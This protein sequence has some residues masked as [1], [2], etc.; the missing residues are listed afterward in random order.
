MWR[1]KSAVLVGLGA[2]LGA[3][4]LV[5][6]PVLAGRIL[7]PVTS[8]EPVAGT[9][10][11]AVSGDGR[12]IF[13]VS[14]SNN[15]GPMANGALNLYRADTSAA[16]PPE[17]SLVLALSGLGNGNCF[18][19]SASN[20]GTV[21]AFETLAT[22]LGG[23]QG[24]FS[25]I[26][27][28][29]QIA[30]PQNEVGFDTLLVSRGLGGVAPNG[31]SRYA[32]TSGD[33]RFVAFWSDASNLIANDSNS[34]PDI[35]IVNVDG[36]QLG[37]T[38]RISVDSNEVQIAGWSRALSN[39]AV[40]GDGRYVV[41]AADATLDGAN[42][43]T[44]EDVYLRDRTAGTTTLLSRFSNGTPFNAAADQ[45]SISPNARYVAFRSFQTGAGIGPSRIFLRDRQS[46]TTT[47]IPAPPTTAACAEPRVSDDADIAMNCAS[48][49]VGVSQQVWFRRGSDGAF[50]RLSSTPG[51]ADGNGASGT[52]I[53][54][55][56]SGDV[57]VFDSAAS[58]LD[59]GD[60]NSSQDVFVGIEE[61]V[62]YAIF[63]DGFE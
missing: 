39:H 50:F 36:G 28:S 19:P 3:G 5:A 32:S 11:P 49:L 57:V 27:A 47:S 1:A 40:S 61:S 38:E 9:R 43:G 35:F 58:N 63:S 10:D 13:F 44:I 21:V 17:L 54:L 48:S 26:Y 8:A 14:T 53:D 7:N 34:A 25:D 41:F 33:G 42:S 12:F 60:G 16:T 52:V 18:A 6:D 31:A 62:L 2:L 59:P 37:P 29:F 15:L 46:N 22:N 20:S 23:T 45:P 56:D 55:S 30:L 24:N 51:N 4:P